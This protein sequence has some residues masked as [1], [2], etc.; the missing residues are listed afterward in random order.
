MSVDVDVHDLRRTAD[1]ATEGDEAPGEGLGE[2][3][4]TALGDRE[5]DGLAHH[6]EQQRHQSRSDVVERDVGVPGVAGQQQSR[7]VTAEAATTQ[8]RGGGE[9]G[10]EQ[11]DAAGGRQPTQA[12]Q[13]VAHRWERRQQRA[14]HVLTDHVP[15]PAQGEPLLT[16]ARVRCIHEGSGDRAVAVQERPVAVREWVAEHGRRVP[17]D[18]AVLLEPEATGSSGTPQPAGRRR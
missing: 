4:G 9:Q 15:L 8:R 6:R 7:P 1:P 17:P 16:V 18:Q 5:A 13:R 12:T 10:P 2:L 11:P 14:D 3:A